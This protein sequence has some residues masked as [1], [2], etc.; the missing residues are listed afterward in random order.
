[1][2]L[3]IGSSST[4]LF[5]A[6]NFA[7]ILGR[8]TVTGVTF[9]GI[10]LAT[11]TTQTRGR[12]LT[13]LARLVDGER[14]PTARFS[15]A[16]T[17]QQAH[18]WERDNVRVAVKV[19]QLQWNTAQKH[20]AGE[21]NPYGAS[22]GLKFRKVRL[23]DPREF[24]ELHLAAYTPRGIYLYRHDFSS[25]VTTA[26]KDTSSVGFDIGLQ[27]PRNEASWEA[28]IDHSILPRLDA[29]DNACKRLA[30]VPFDDPRLEAA[31]ATH[32][33]TVTEQTYCGVPLADCSAAVR[34]SVLSSLVRAVDTSLHPNASVDDP[35]PG[36]RV[37]GRRRGMHQA[38][39]SWRR[40]ASRVACK[41]AQLK[42][43]KSNRMWE[44]RFSNIKLGYAGSRPKNGA[45]VARPRD[46]DELLLAL[47]TPRGVLVYRHDLL[48][49]VTPAGK[50]T[51]SSGHVIKLCGPRG[52]EDWER[53]LQE[54]LLPALDRSG[55]ECVAEVRW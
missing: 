19:A 13:A 29:S 30:Y 37:D 3:P 34:A 28:V 10:P 4:A 40:D 47:Y 48:L 38:A 44:L 11:S 2:L 41:G 8:R 21:T 36:I 17:Y 22:W 18:G 43:D 14:H 1:M 16:T 12:I 24:D 32:P 15:D 31:F 27:G 46:F 39:Y 6:S 20:W 35:V 7:E 50:R 49:G 45:A 51:A 33:P 42:W 54:T 9:D 55:C 23:G 5:D 25:G 52:Q 53:A 26:G